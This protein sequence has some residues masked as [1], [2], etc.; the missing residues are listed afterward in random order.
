MIGGTML[1]K[2]KQYKQK[3]TGTIATLRYGFNNYYSVEGTG[4]TLQQDY[5]ESSPEWELVPEVKL[6]RFCIRYLTFEEA[7][8]QAADANR[9]AYLKDKYSCPYDVK[10]ILEQIDQNNV[11]ERHKL[12]FMSKTGLEYMEENEKL[13]KEN[14][15]LRKQAM[16]KTEQDHK[17]NVCKMQADRNIQIQQDEYIQILQKHNEL[18]RKSIEAKDKEI[19]NANENIEARNTTIRL[20]KELKLD[21]CKHYWVKESGFLC[22][23]VIIKC[24]HCNTTITT[25]TK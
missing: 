18:Y 25:R 9:K 4:L 6:P 23:Y 16:L 13:K 15:T 1:K 17:L 14:D 8:A 7:E 11:A 5:I 3:S 19:R 22:P 12:C 21:R 10:K 24:K 20:L 2:M